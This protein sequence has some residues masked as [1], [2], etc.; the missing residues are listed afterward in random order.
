MS[1]NAD[2]Q[3]WQKARAHLMR[4]GGAFSPLIAESAGAGSCLAST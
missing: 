3:F 4:Y 2:P 1:G